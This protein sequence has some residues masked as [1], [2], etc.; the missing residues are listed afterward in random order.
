MAG[1]KNKGLWQWQKVVIQKSD[2]QLKL[3]GLDLGGFWLDWQE[4]RNQMGVDFQLF[5]LDHKVAYKR[6]LFK[7]KKYLKNYW[8]LW[9]DLKNFMFTPKLHRKQN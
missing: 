4:L 7:E 2:L 3:F 5:W 6:N 1:D 8:Y 9:R